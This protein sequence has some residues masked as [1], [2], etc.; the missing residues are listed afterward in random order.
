MEVPLVDLKRQY[1]NIKNEIDEAVHTVLDSG[2]FILGPNVA[3]LEEEVA[4]Y[5][6]TRFAVGVASGTDALELS[7]RA[8]NIGQGDEVITS[9]FTFIATTEAICRVGARPVFADIKPGCFTIDPK[10]VEDKITDRTRAVIPVHL[11][12]QACDM[13]AILEL[14]D[15]YNLKIIEDCAQAM[16]SEYNGRKVGSIGSIGCFSFFPTKNLGAYGDGGIVVTNNQEFAERIKMLR[17]HGSKDK[18]HHVMQGLNSRLDELQAAILR[19][20]L[21]YLDGWNKARRVNARLYN[22]LLNT[23]KLNNEL[24]LP[25][26]LPG[27]KHIYHLYVVRTRLRDKLRQWLRDKGISTL[28]HYPLSLHL[29]EVYRDLGYK[30]GDFSNSELASKEV[31]SLPMHPELTDKEIA[32]VADSIIDFFK[33]IL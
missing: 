29:Q 7:L 31:L 2:S 17:H 28:I 23:R 3:A 15:R 30:E 10:E 18:Y 8:L 5:C 21:K 19:V 13:D 27:N 11:Y 16:G 26:E 6:G 9:P 4:S 20:K 22:N 24:I 14:A 1:S 12:G 32:Y 25:K 33:N